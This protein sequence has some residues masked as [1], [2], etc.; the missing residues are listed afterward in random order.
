MM[1]AST[2]PSCPQCQS[3]KHTR[4]QAGGTFVC[5]KC[6]GQFDNDPNEGGDY[7]DRDPAARLLRREGRGRPRR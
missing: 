5:G 2:L 6:G 3:S 1:A 4:A 7:S